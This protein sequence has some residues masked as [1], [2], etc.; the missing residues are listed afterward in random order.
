[1]Y[2]LACVVFECLTGEIPFRRDNQAALVYA[3]LMAEP[4]KVTERRPEL[5]EAI[6]GVV[7]KG[8]AKK[9]EDR[10]VTAGEMVAE[11][12]AALGEGA[13][14]GRTVTP[15]LTR[16]STAPGARRGPLGKRGR[17]A[18]GAG[19]V[20]ALVVGAVL[21]LNRG[22]EG[23]GA[24]GPSATSSAGAT[25]A[26]AGKDRLVRIDT[27]TRKIVAAIPMGSSPAGVVAAEGSVWVASS[28]RNSVSRV[29]PVTNKIDATIPVGKSPVAIAS[30]DG[31]IWVANSLSNSVSKIDPG[32]N[33]VVATIG[34][35]ARP[36]TIAAGDDV[37]AVGTANEQSDFPPRSP[38]LVID[39]GSGTTIST[40][41]VPGICAPFVSEAER[42]IWTGSG[43]GTL[44]KLDAQS[45][46][47]LTRSDLGAAIS[48]I[49][50]GEDGV[51]YAGTDGQPAQV[52]AIDPDSLE[53]SATIP[54][55]TT[56]N[57]SG[58][59]CDPIAITAG[60][61]YVWVTNRDDGTISQVT[62]ISNTVVAAIDVGRNP[63][64]VALGFNSL[65]VTVDA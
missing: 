34:V 32:T 12:K 33:R 58:A 52:R 60:G 20:V 2:S 23:G 59:S 6:D 19:L 63:I 16:P 57:I 25:A 47:E 55:G 3:H 15:P 24:V 29:N 42:I 35:E 49:T 5:P 13:S 45:G 28:S 9:A 44:L 61:Q 65:W 62:A 39:Q 56:R 22:G 17:V 46:K 14:T 1:V 41:N 31:F 11:S 43:A 18:V 10:Y 26:L 37:L 50:V 4:P 8:M 38:V 48:G 36:A 7:A 21:L 64:G 30:G 54:V 53:V 27:A 40:V 51:V